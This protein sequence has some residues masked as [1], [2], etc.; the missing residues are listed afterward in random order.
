MCK[1]STAMHSQPASKNDSLDTAACSHRDSPRSFRLSTGSESLSSSSCLTR[2]LEPV[3]DCLLPSQLLTSAF[4]AL[5]VHAALSMPKATEALCAR[6][7]RH[8][9]SSLR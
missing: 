2:A 1:R 8:S 5:L 7:R 6:C 9:W 4:R 3:D